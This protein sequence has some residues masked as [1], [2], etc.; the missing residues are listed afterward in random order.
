MRRGATTQV[1]YTPFTGGLDLV[2]SALAV[3]P[4]RLA[5]CINYEQVFGKQGYRRIDGYERFD[6]QAQPSLAN[7]WIQGFKLG[8]A[9]VNVGDVVS[10]ASVTATV[11]AVVLESGAWAAGNAVGYLVLGTVS[12]AWGDGSAINVVAAQKATAD[13]VTVTGSISQA[14]NTAYLSLAREA[15]RTK[16]QQIPGS[17]PVLGVAVYRNNVYAVRNV[18]DGT[19][20]TLWKSSAAGWTAVRT[21]MY[22]GGTYRFRV[23][24]FSANSTTIALFGVNGKGRM[25]KYDGSA[26]TYAAPIYGSEATSTSSL[27]IGTGDKAFSIPQSTRS[28]QVGDSLI[29]WDSGN[30]A[31][32]MSGTVKTYASDT[33]TLTV[34]AKGG[35]GSPAAWEIGKADF[36]DKPF[37]LTDHRDHLFLAYPL[38]QLQSSNLGDPMTYTT[39]AGLFG[40]GDEI[41]GL[42]SLKGAVLGVFCRSKIQMLA[43][44]SVSDWQMNPHSR[45]AGARYGSLQ[46]NT[47]NA[48]FLDDKGVISLQATQAFGNFEPAVFSRDIKPYLDARIAKLVGSRMVRSK[49]QYRMY[50]NDGIRLTAAILSPDPIIQP[51]SVA[52]TKQQT[53]HIPTCFADGDMADGSV[54]MFFGTTDGYVMREDVGPSFDGQPIVSVARLQFNQ[55]KLPANKKRFRKLVLEMEASDSVDINFRQQFDYSDGNYDASNTQDA[56]ASGFGGAWD[57]AQWD[58]FYWSQPLVTQAEANIDGVGRNMSL[59]LWHQ[60]ADVRPFVLQGLLTHY[61]VLGM[62]R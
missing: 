30:A 15:L 58:T 46:D 7:Y 48:L 1:S 18:A 24:N 57:A 54:G 52:F 35:T 60:S 61:S 2:S 27:A 8:T 33:L 19:T 28:W 26:F 56:Q 53:S 42:V 62:T 12:G 13:G 21:G 59:L 25:F 49:Y 38:G 50:F 55:F 36:T 40:L 47:G 17:G 3:A 34:T 31:N 44:N 11:L 51:N 43:G 9:A 14:N 20:A 10:G 22:P 41:S 6:G 16:I 37:D 32:W 23:A 45:T 5:E 39:S 4:G 29:A